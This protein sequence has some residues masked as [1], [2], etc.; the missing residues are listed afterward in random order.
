MGLAGCS[1]TS[2]RAAS[3]TRS[4]CGRTVYFGNPARPDLLRAAGVGADRLLVAA[5]ENVYEILW[6]VDVAEHITRWRQAA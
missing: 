5:L 3:S 6:A 1:A 4:A 2:P